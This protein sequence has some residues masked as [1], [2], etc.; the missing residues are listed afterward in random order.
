M[1]T[2]TRLNL[3]TSNNQTAMLLVAAG[4]TPT[5]LELHKEI[6][7]VLKHK[8]GLKNL[9]TFCL[10]SGKELELGDLQNNLTICVSSSS[11]KATFD[12]SKRLARQDPSA[13]CEC[14]IRVIGQ[15]FS[16][17]QVVSSLSRFAQMPGVVSVLALPD[18]S[19][20]VPCPVGTSVTVNGRLY[21]SWIGTDIG[22]GVSLLKFKAKSLGSVDKLIQRLSASYTDKWSA[23]EQARAFRERFM[24]TALPLGVDVCLEEHD[25]TFGSIGAGN[26]FCELQ[27]CHATGELYLA[28]HSGSRSLGVALSEKMALLCEGELDIARCLALQQVGMEWARL[29]RLAIAKRV[30][31]LMLPPNSARFSSKED[32]A[33]DLVL[34]VCHNFIQSAPES[35]YIHRKGAIPTDLGPVLIPGSRGTN[36]YMVAAT[37]E[38]NSLPHGAGRRYTKADAEKKFSTQANHQEQQKHG[39]SLCCCKCFDPCSR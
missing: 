11:S 21:P 24:T 26:H 17:P 20:A 31:D 5:L 10:V 7:Q 19:A 12:I 16:Q 15:E 4:R 2:K 8:F 23:V 35:M 33:F 28:V 25:D 3:L 13:L 37:S 30:V 36:S 6:Q 18:L 14:E 27:E 32:D 1:T 29:N 22:C 9:D 38:L 34:D 39:T